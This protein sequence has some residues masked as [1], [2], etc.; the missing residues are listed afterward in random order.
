MGG[1]FEGSLSLKADS[2]FVPLVQMVPPLP[3]GNTFITEE[4]PLDLQEAKS[5]S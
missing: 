1:N 4:K 3:Q 2:A 5:L